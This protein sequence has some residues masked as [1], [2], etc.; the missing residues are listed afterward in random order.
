VTRDLERFLRPDEIAKISRLELR[1]RKVVE[2]F[3]SGLHRSPY[4][5]Q[6]IEFVQHRE[7][8]PGDDTRRIDWKVWSRTDRYYLKQFE[9]DTNVRVVL[10]VDGSESMQ[11][12]SGALTKFDYAQTVAAALA[13]LILK[14]NDSVGVGLFD[15]KMRTI[16]PSSSRHNHLQTVLQ[17]LSA[18]TADGKTDMIGVLRKAAEVMSHRSIVILI[19]D[20]F[21]DREELFR[22]LSLL[23]Q[24]KHEVLVVHTMDDQELDFDYAGTMQF[25]GL[26]ESGKLTCDPAQLRSGYHNALQEFL[27]TIRRRCAGSTIDYRLTRTSE[28]LDAV[29]SE[30]LNFRIGMRKSV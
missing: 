13:M 17:G 21:C 2:G 23:R 8:V 3:V 27:E 5:G 4:F 7:Y 30:L 14:Q 19:S 1:A 25:E 10:L 18:E 15:S 29:L 12:G 6:S 16:I 28:H 26:E 9:E 20:L 22:G 11:F 24:R